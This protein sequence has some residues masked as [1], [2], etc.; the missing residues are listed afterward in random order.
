MNEIKL[1]A[2]E[3]RFADIIWKNE[4]IKAG[5]LVKICEKEM[6]WKRTTTSAWLDSQSTILP[7]PSSPHW[8]P[9]TTT[10]AMEEIPS[11]LT[12]QSFI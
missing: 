4:P 10:F 12:Y 1:A 6:S 5:E 7:L 2:G 9:T 3:A 8:A 11:L